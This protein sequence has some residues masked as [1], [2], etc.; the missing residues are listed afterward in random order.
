MLLLFIPYRHTKY[1]TNGYQPNRTLS[2]MNSITGSPN[3]FQCAN[4][5][6]YGRQ[7]RSVDDHKH[8]VVY[9]DTDSKFVEVK[10]GITKEDAIKMVLST[11]E[12]PVFS[13]RE[14]RL[15]KD[16]SRYLRPYRSNFDMKG[17]E[18]ERNLESDRMNIEIQ[19]PHMFNLLSGYLPRFENNHRVPALTNSHSIPIWNSIDAMQLNRAAMQLNRAAAVSRPIPDRSLR[20]LERNR[21]NKHRYEK[22]SQ[23]IVPKN[24]KH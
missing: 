3:L 4:T 13:E 6:S 15:W 19:V 11:T 24:Q 22:K 9:S 20:L 10:A 14:Q 5:I 12:M 2:S 17:S 16:I 21:R 1:P 18:Q 8:D 7:M 23:A